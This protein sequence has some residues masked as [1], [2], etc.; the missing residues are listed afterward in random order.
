MPKCEYK[1]AIDFDEE[2]FYEYPFFY[3]PENESYS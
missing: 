1:T 3:K 2:V